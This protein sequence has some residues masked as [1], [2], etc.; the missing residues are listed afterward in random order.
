ML[1]IL[2][3]LYSCSAEGNYGNPN[4]NIPELDETRRCENFLYIKNLFLENQA[5][6]DD[7]L[8]YFVQIQS[9]RYCE[10]KLR[11]QLGE[12]WLE[13]KG[14]YVKKQNEKVEEFFQLLEDKK[15]SCPGS[16]MDIR[17]YSYDNGI[18]FER[19]IIIFEISLGNRDKKYSKIIFENIYRD[20][21]QLA[22]GWYY[23]IEGKTKL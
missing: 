13:S 12:L 14:E 5:D 20:Q 1:S 23:S 22:N 7:I 19:P 9:N 18:A 2:C 11:Y 4:P 6:F 10:Y 3:P 8:H 15:F 17:Y 16:Q 21:L